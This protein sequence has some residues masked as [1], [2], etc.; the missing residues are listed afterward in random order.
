MPSFDIVSKFNIQE[1]ENSVNMVNRDIV[2][3]FDFRGSNTKLTLNKKENN[4]II[5]TNSEMRLDIVRDMLEK[6]ALGRSVSLKTFV[7]Y[8]S[9]KASGMSVR[10]KIDLYQGI[11]KDNAKKINKF[12]KGSKLK[13]Q[14][15]IQDDQIR[16]NAKKIDN[17]QKIIS[18]LK[19]ENMDIP[20]QFVNMKNN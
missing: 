1:I 15:Q 19:E 11:S 10:Q 13:V 14:S 2:N 17:L 6:R 18:L 4:I 12:I 5:E 9:E 7:F 20:L 8:D 16:V 3:R